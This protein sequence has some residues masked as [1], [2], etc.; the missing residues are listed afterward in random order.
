[1]AS[2]DPFL[3]LLDIAHRSRE[4]ARGLPKRE[5]AEDVWSGVGFIIGGKHYVSP[6]GEVG[7]TMKMPRFTPIPRVRGWVIGLANIRGRLVPLLDLGQYLVRHS[8][9]LSGRCRVMIIEEEE[10]TC[11][12]IVDAVLGMQRLP[13]RGFDRH[14]NDVPESIFRFVRGAYTRGDEEWTVFSLLE[15]SKD[16]AFREVALESSVGI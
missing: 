13:V 8:S 6:L 16:D 2:A 3:T 4:H 7:E 1:M 9:Q 12:F 5:E 14:V 15:L 11:G 10:L